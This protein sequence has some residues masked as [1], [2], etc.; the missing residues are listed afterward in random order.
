MAVMK[1]VLRR[2]WHEEEAQDL[3]EYALVIVLIALVCVAAMNTLAGG[4]ENVFNTAA[5]NLSVS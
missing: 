4:I 2:L 5:S 1:Q 3:T